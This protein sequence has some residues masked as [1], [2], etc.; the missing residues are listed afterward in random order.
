VLVNLLDNAHKYGTGG[1]GDVE[2]ETTAN[3]QL[4][5]WNPGAPI[6]NNVAQHMFEPFASSH[7]R[8]SG[9]GLYLSRELCQRYGAQLAYQPSS[10]HGMAGHGFVV[11]F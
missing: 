11:T 5:V 2:V 1:T 8:S 9:L 7:S 3:G 4:V 10:R 6:T